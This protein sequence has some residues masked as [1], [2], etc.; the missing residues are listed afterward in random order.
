MSGSKADR[1][2]WTPSSEYEKW[3]RAAQLY[4][5]TMLSNGPANQRVS[6]SP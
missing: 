1:S 3:A 6:P 5:R 2:R 4:T